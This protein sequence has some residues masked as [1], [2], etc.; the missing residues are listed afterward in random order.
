MRLRSQVQQPQVKLE[1]T[2]NP[3]YEGY[4]QE[5]KAHMQGHGAMLQSLADARMDS[6]IL[7]RKKKEKQ[8]RC[9]RVEG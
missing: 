1:P 6:D 2:R 5:I 8:K 4:L 9:I 7:D 3:T